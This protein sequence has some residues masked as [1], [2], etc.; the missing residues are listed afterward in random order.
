MFFI[1]KDMITKARNKESILFQQKQ[2]KRLDF[3]NIS[4]CVYDKH[5]VLINDIFLNPNI[6]SFVSYNDKQL[7]SWNPENKEIISSIIFNDTEQP[8]NKQVS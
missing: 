8:K 3:S 6:N 7:H 4:L 2:A 5:K 1:I